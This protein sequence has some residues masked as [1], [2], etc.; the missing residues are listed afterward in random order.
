MDLRRIR[1]FVVL[2]ETLNY[3][4]AAERLHMAQPPLTVSIQKLEAELGTRLFERS[5]TGVALT[6]SGRAVLAE[7]RKLLFHG[8]QLQA[9][10][11]DVV[12]GT[13]GTLRVGFVGTTTYGMLQR[14]LPQ[15]RTEYP[16]VNLVL[17]ESTSVAILE[18]LEDHAL[19]VGLV[20]TPLL[21]PT[22]A[23]LVQLE[24]DHFV[25]ALPRGHE[26][27]Q[28]GPLRL[29]ELADESFVMYSA[30]AAAGLR[31]AAM[32]ACQAAGFVPKVSQEAVQVQTL[33]ALVES[34]TG[35][36]LVPSVMQRYASDKLL[37]RPLEDLPVA[38]EVGLALAY[39]KGSEIPAAS[40]FRDV[41]VRVCSDRS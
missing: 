18:Q 28:Q 40:R 39:L 23:A 10:A 27:T 19:D 6:P 13:G 25:V 41:A 11:R 1:H 5:S 22:R 17:R 33:L 30:T 38:S 16:G 26:L 24:H 37:Y 3:R 2:A 9:V 15:F 36:A 4:R 29:S 20:R 35:V 12:E 31:S 7:A 34:G 32:L 8:G 14:L 21:R